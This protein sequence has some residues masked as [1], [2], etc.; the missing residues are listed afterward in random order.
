MAFTSLSGLNCFGCL[1]N[2]LG[3]LNAGLNV[4]ISGSE[5]RLLLST[6]PP[7]RFSAAVF[8][9][10]LGFAQFIGGSCTLKMSQNEALKGRK[11]RYLHQLYVLQIVS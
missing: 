6:S 1:G 10:L 3:N 8:C 4:V 9:T 11:V 2:W 7:I 5:F